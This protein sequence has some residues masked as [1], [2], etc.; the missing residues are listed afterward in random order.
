VQRLLLPTAA[1]GHVRSA[2]LIAARGSDRVQAVWHGSSRRLLP[3]TE[4]T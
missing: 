1:D 3:R 2:F 4:R